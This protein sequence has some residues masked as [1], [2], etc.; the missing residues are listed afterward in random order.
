MLANLSVNGENRA[1]QSAPPCPCASNCNSRFFIRALT[2][3]IC[4]PPCRFRGA[5]GRGRVFTSRERLGQSIPAGGAGWPFPRV[6]KP[7]AVSDVADSTNVELYDV[8]SIS[9]HG[10]FRSSNATRLTGGPALWS[11]AAGCRAR[12]V[13]CEHCNGVH[14]VMHQHIG[15]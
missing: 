15:T 10:T 4:F 2:A 14:R 5:V 12:S 7:C 11:G 13:H 1:L 6:I 9:M 8:F 3:E